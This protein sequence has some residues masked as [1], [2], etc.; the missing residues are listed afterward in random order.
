MILLLRISA[1]GFRTQG[2]HRLRLRPITWAVGSWGRLGAFVFRSALVWVVLLI[3]GR[4]IVRALLP[5]PGALASWIG[6]SYGGWAKRRR[7][8]RRERD[9]IKAYGRGKTPPSTLDH[10]NQQETEKLL[11]KTSFLQLN[12]ISEMAQVFIFL[13]QN[14]YQTEMSTWLPQY[15]RWVPH[16]YHEVKTV[17]CTILYMVSIVIFIWPQNSKIT[18]SCM[19][20]VQRKKNVLLSRGIVA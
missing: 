16:K 18:N 10:Q 7:E 6:L 13:F 12:F 8:N 3:W 17:L 14:H 2:D 5:S 1:A 9:A 19:R 15:S 11:W 4:G 20:T